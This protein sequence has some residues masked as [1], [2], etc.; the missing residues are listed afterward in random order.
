MLCYLA[1]V[2]HPPVKYDSHRF[3]VEANAG[4]P[5]QRWHAYSLVPSLAYDAEPITTSDERDESR[6]YLP[7]WI[8]PGLVVAIIREVVWLAPLLSEDDFSSSTSDAI[9]TATEKGKISGWVYLPPL[10]A[11]EGR[12]FVVPMY[13]FTRSWWTTTARRSQLSVISTG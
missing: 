11:S 10:P 9:F 3:W 12:G 8:G 7:T 5:P 4:E 13:S 1:H 6:I 2:V